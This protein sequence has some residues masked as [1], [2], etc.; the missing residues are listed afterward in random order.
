MVIAVVETVAGTVTELPAPPVITIDVEPA[1]SDRTLTVLPDTD[2]VTALG[3]P[4]IVAV[5]KAPE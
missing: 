1:C 5:V 4:P 3:S 2:A